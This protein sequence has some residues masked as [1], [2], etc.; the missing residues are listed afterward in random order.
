MSR[1]VIPSYTIIRDTREKE[2]YGWT[3]QSHMADHRPPRCDG[4]ITETLN[5]PLENIFNY[6]LTV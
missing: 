4:M 3:F 1:L 5:N 2:G 6:N